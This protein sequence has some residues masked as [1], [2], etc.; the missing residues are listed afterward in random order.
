MGLF[1]SC[2]EALLHVATYS[3]FLGSQDLNRQQPFSITPHH[4]DSHV[5][6]PLAGPSFKVAGTNFTCSYPSMTGY[7]SCNGAHDRNCWLRPSN[8]KD[9]HYNIHTKYDT[10][11][12][13]FTPVGVVREACSI[14]TSLFLTI[15]QL[16]KCSIGL[17]WTSCP[18]LQTAI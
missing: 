7:R 10:P 6:A 5:S 17:T 1:T 9:T 3:S 8:S 15:D 18:L 4:A 14:A 16:T 11:G 13:D 12:D 2:W